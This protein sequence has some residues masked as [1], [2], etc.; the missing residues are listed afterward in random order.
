VQVLK[1]SVPYRTIRA[2]RSCK[3]ALMN[4]FTSIRDLGTEGAGYT[5][6]DLKKAIKNNATFGFKTFVITPSL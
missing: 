4:G 1:E 5:D 2:V 6:V 3:Q